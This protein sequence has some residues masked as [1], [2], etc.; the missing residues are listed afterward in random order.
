[1]EAIGAF[2]AILGVPAV[3]S[4]QAVMWESLRILGMSAR[5]PRLGR[6]FRL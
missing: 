6:L 5:D 1:M 3:T 2:E 4:N